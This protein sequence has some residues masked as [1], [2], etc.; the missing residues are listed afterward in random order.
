MASGN[1]TRTTDKAKAKRDIG[2]Y[3]AV[4]V[5]HLDTR[6]MGGLEV[7][8]IRYTGSGGTPEAGGELVQVRY[9]SPFYGVTPAVGLT[10]NDGYQNTQKSYGM[11]AVP[12]DIG[13]RVLVIFAE[14]NPN[15]GYWIGCIPD[16]Y[17]NFMVPDGRAST[18]NTTA[19]TP[20][21]I[22]GSKLPVGEYNKAY[23][24]GELLDP[25]LFNK[26]Y[27]KDFTETL[28]TQGLIYDEARGTTT[29]SARREIPSMVFGISTPGPKDKRD[30]SPKVTIGSAEDKLDSHFNRLG[31][32]SFVMDDG[33]PGLLRKTHPED[34]PP[35]YINKVD[36]EDGGRTTIPHN[37]LV[38]LRT[39]TGHQILM[40]NSE[41]LIYIGNSRGTTWIEMTSDGKIDIHAQDSVSIMT[42]NDLNVTAERDI[43]F[44]AGRNI[45]LKA[46]AR[47]SKGNETDTKGLESGRV[48][49]EAQNNYNLLAGKDARITVANDMHTGVAGNQFITTSKFLNISSGQD[50]RLTAGS[51]THISSGKEHRETA[52]YVHM[53]GPK[54]AQAQRA[55][56]VV[57]LETIIM[58][59]VFPGSSTPVI[60]DSIVPRAPQHEP[61]PH[62]ENLEPS[63]FKK[64]ETDREAP[65]ALA[66]ADRVL[67]PDTFLKN[68]GG[69]TRSAFVTNS[70]GSIDSGF[71]TTSGGT[72]TGQGE[73]PR[74]DY[75][76]SFQFTDELGKLSEKYE[77]RGN[78]TAIGFDST[79][80]WSYGTYQIA[81][82]VGAFKGYMKYLNRK[83]KSTYEKLQEAGGNS[84]ATG[85]TDTFKQ[86][87]QLAMSDKAN[88][89]TQHSYAVVQYF[90]PAADKVT[91][92][93]GI[94]VRVKSKTLQ[95]VLWSTAIQHGAGGCN[96]VFKNAVKACGTDT[97]TD[98]ALIVAI[99]NERAR[100]NG[101]AYFGRSTVAVRKSVVQ[102]FNNE[103][104]DALKSLEQ[105]LKQA[106]TPTQGGDT[107]SV[108]LP[109]GP[110]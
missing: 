65:G 45:N 31:G 37:E 5:N 90:V 9:L 82:K 92:S 94:D 60:Y 67:T 93:T 104:L 6:Y 99:Y 28:E 81:S 1:Y 29:T 80:G 33:D 107:G 11:W 58:P 22:K 35:I 49:I 53:N 66:T 105:E 30:G 69:M 85:G 87:W 20:E 8:L 47:Y 25:T 110:Q 56:T 64:P 73:P 10:P 2:P 109:V 12:P 32:S 72:S 17:M 13:T 86:T 68:K 91:K 77:S 52:T 57:P 48:Q 44:E 71:T 39:R 43:N 15:F 26:P 88:A 70:G 76:S 79:G 34:G 108:T 18:V 83:H 23:E 16:D 95:D 103:K 42:D 63:S 46:S 98:D 62:H 89:E 101:S 19:L 50:N 61:W 14:G 102:R 27:N 55:K 38:R 75:S 3:E 4:V 24:T 59:Y 96:R 84:A 54:A 106:G 41:D 78:P 21:N 36:G 97:P 100:D 51:Y 74:A 7:E 40:H